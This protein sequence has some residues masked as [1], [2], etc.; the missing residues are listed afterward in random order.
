MCVE[1]EDMGTTD[2]V[3]PTDNVQGEEQPPEDEDIEQ[4]YHLLD[5]EMHPQDTPGDDEY[6]PSQYHWDDED[7]DTGSLFG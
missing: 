2:N 7:D 1:K 6:P 5:E 4:D 3:A